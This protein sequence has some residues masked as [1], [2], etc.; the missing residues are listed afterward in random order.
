[1]YSSGGQRYPPN[2]GQY[3]GR[4]LPAPSSGQGLLP[5][6]SSGQA[7]LPPPSSGQSLLPHPGNIPNQENMACQGNVPYQRNLSCQANAFV[8]GVTQHL[9]V[10]Q[11]LSCL[12]TPLFVPTS[13]RNNCPPVPTAATMFPVSSYQPLPRPVFASGLPPTPVP[14]CSIP[15]NQGQISP[16]RST[17]IGTNISPGSYR[18]PDPFSP[19]SPH[20]Q[21]QSDIPPLL[22][23]PMVPQPLFRRGMN[24]PTKKQS[25]N[26]DR[27]LNKT[28]K[29]DLYRTFGV[30][31]QEHGPLE[32]TDKRLLSVFMGL[33]PFQRQGIKYLGGLKDFFQQ[34]QIFD[35]DGD[36]VCLVWQKEEELTGKKPTGSDN[37]QDAKVQQPSKFATPAKG[38]RSSASPVLASPQ[39][40]STARAGEK[41]SDG[42]GQGKALVPGN[43]VPGD[44]VPEHQAE[45]SNETEGSDED[46][47]DD[48][49][50]GE[51]EEEEEGEYGWWLIDSIH[52]EEEDWK[53]VS[54]LQG[55][56]G[57]GYFD[58]FRLLEKE[59]NKD[60]DEEYRKL[61]TLSSPTES[62]D[63]ESTIS[64]KSEGPVPLL[65]SSPSPSNDAKKPVVESPRESQESSQE[66]WTDAESSA[67]EIDQESIPQ[68]GMCTPEE[69]D[70]ELGE[71]DAVER[72]AGGKELGS[73]TTESFNKGSELP[74]APTPCMEDKSGDEEIVYGSWSIHQ[75]EDDVLL[76]EVVEGSTDDVESRSAEEEGSGTGAVGDMES[77]TSAAVDEES[78]TGAARDDKSGTGAA[79]D[80]ESGTGATGDEESGEEGGPAV[81]GTQVCNQSASADDQHGEDIIT[82]VIK[83]A[84]EVVVSSSV[85][86]EEDVGDGELSSIISKLDIVSQ[87]EPSVTPDDVPTRED[88]HEEGIAKELL[89]YPD[90]SCGPGGDSSITLL[91]PKELESRDIRQDG[92]RDQSFNTSMIDKVLAR[93][94]GVT[95]AP[96]LSHKSVST[97]DV[98]TRSC[99][100]NTKVL[101]T[102]S[103]G[104]ETGED[105]RVEKLQEDLAKKTEKCVLLS[106][107]V[108]DM[109]DKLIHQKN[110]HMTERRDLE[111]QL[112]I[113]NKK[114]QE[115]QRKL[116]GRASVEISE[117]QKVTEELKDSENQLKAARSKI[118]RADKENSSLTKELEK[119]TRQLLDL[120]QSQAKQ[121]STMDESTCT[122][123][124]DPPENQ[125]QSQEIGLLKMR[126]RSAEQKVLELQYQYAMQSVNKALQES[127]YIFRM[128]G[129]SLLSSSHQESL[130]V[131]WLNYQSYIK[132]KTDEVAATFY[133]ALKALQENVPLAEVPSFKAQL[134]KTFN[135]CEQTQ[136]AP[137][138]TSLFS[139]PGTM[140]QTYPAP[141]TPAGARVSADVSSL[142]GASQPSMAGANI[143]S[144]MME[145]HTIRQ[146]PPGLLGES[147]TVPRPIA[148]TVPPAVPPGL[149]SLQINAATLGMPFTQAHTQRAAP[150][151][152]L[153]RAPRKTPKAFLA[154]NFM[155]TFN[156]TTKVYGARA[157]VDSK[158][159]VIGVPF[160][161]GL[162]S[163]E[164]TGAVDDWLDTLDTNSQVTGQS[165]VTKSVVQQ[166]PPG[167]QG[168]QS[169]VPVGTSQLSNTT[170]TQGNELP[171]IRVPPPVNLSRHIVIGRGRTHA[172]G[173]PRV[174]FPG[175]GSQKTGEKT[176]QSSEQKVSSSGPSDVTPSLTSTSSQMSSRSLSPFQVDAAPPAGV[177]R[178]SPAGAACGEGPSENGVGLP[179]TSQHPMAKAR[180]ASAGDAS[181]LSTRPES[182]QPTLVGSKA[183]SASL[184]QPVGSSA[185]QAKA[186]APALDAE[187]K[188][189]SSVDTASFSNIAANPKNPRIDV[190]DIPPRFRAR[191]ARMPYHRGAEG[192]YGSD[193]KQGGSDGDSSGD[194]WT[195]KTSQQAGKRKGKTVNL[196]EQQARLM[197]EY[198][199]LARS[200]NTGT[201]GGTR[202]KPKPKG[203]LDKLIS[204]LSKQFQN[205]TRQELTDAILQVRLDHNGSLSGIAMGTIISEAS[206]YLKRSQKQKKAKDIVS[207]CVVCQEE[208]EGNPNK[209]KLD[210]GHTFH[211]GCIKVWVNEE[212]TCPVC[213]KHTLFAEDFPRLN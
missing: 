201:G 51:E 128:Y 163:Q 111:E 209:R 196:V 141:T 151:K 101:V 7:L 207:M 75:A 202:D 107:D 168:L 113:L 98:K 96:L 43:R 167:F 115:S 47:I 37:Q 164:S 127:Q 189:S 72:Q 73:I 26:A 93:S 165:Q 174:F 2:S 149:G 85:V 79:G 108:G 129:N 38:G 89:T 31:L 156:H 8:P 162:P 193:G 208:M 13:A 137:S 24:T 11:P 53:S 80:D 41:V 119:T 46:G 95:A 122:A 199:S 213:R 148:V 175:G 117:L 203:S 157:P 150:G 6:P 160:P 12:P 176:E 64:D 99:K 9:T 195:T 125:A 206:N 198:S 52:G 200:H 144:N 186:S 131:R 188:P 82:E 182:S 40:P 57:G 210:C 65:A 161:Q 10:I 44:Q 179:T 69:W 197:K 21:P 29:A 42:R 155:S 180:P 172:A 136:A 81:E 23:S 170:Q 139:G 212:G 104:T 116:Q 194:G 84:D 59:D 5:P 94:V 187:A 83:D 114:Q 50:E 76:V 48:E 86:T 18:P 36:V 204:Y 4:L 126:A 121:A 39:K 77:E 102:V 134:I 181:A 3:Q 22:P 120:E 124:L 147:L 19:T 33:T 88:K 152:V 110:Q 154:A 35:L 27:S 68:D 173:A 192:P 190:T 103:R 143:R 166:P 87:S 20:Q 17:N 132:E 105:P 92:E 100:V 91:T 90:D 71:N 58:D 191:Q 183:R 55:R 49:W 140:P 171:N 30:V 135:P 123:G 109:R 142:S 133:S 14:P 28:E 146:P 205:M 66:R 138:M 32:V 106:A 78:G 74:E 45:S 67:E 16:N 118:H 184:G 56:I 62:N 25:T 1:M 153:R 70:K 178:G 54:P 159:G 60:P 211:S 169:T 34:S 15:G 185:E 145:Q 112:G 63:A 97:K 130:R 158:D 61:L 177:K